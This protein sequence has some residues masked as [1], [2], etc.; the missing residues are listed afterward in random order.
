MT[1]VPRLK[2]ERATDESQKGKKDTFEAHQPSFLPFWFCAGKKKE[3]EGRD[4]WKPTPAKRRKQ[5]KE[6]SHSANWETHK[7]Q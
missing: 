2:R 4:F 7:G 3:E 5:T 6:K 1:N